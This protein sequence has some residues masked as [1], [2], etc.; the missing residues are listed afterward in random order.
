[1]RATI[2]IVGAGVVEWAG[3]IGTA[4][5]DTSFPEG[6]IQRLR[7]K[8][9]FASNNP[10][11]RRLDPLS[12]CVLVAAEAA[13][14]A[15]LI[16]PEHRGGTALVSASRYGCLPSDLRFERSL[17][18]ERKTEP[19]VFPYT[20]PSTCLGELAVRHGFQ[21]PMLCLTDHAGALGEGLR[22]A[23]TLIELG[24]AD[25]AIVCL[26]D[27][28]GEEDAN[29]LKLEPVCAVAAVVLLPGAGRAAVID[30]DELLAAE[31]PVEFLIAHLRATCVAPEKAP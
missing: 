23:C 14:V 6:G 21:G 15:E 1:M 31:Y 2:R 5:P 7:W 24:E 12:R 28:L 11:F 17:D 4:L 20:L 29:A 18:P 25:S 16:P 9:F 10:T 19:A 13:G 30:Q 3:A 26:G 27:F 22:E 8:P